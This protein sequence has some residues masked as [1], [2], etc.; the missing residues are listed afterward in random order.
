M[1]ESSENLSLSL[2]YFLEGKKKPSWSYFYESKKV[3]EE[4]MT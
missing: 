3:P 4:I 2:L 1:D